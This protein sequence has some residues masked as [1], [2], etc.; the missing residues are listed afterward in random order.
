MILPEGE[1]TEGYN[2]TIQV[3]IVSQSGAREVDMLTV[4]VC[5][6][7]RLFLTCMKFTLELEF[8][9]IIFM[10]R[11]VNFYFKLYE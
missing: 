10:L 6:Q 9:I 11:K 5:L 4:K 2:V 1:K 7:K 8:L 3:E